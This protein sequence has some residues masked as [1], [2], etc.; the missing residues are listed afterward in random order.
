M[1]EFAT[2]NWGAL[3]SVLG[4][5]GSLAGLGWVIR[6]ARGA[7]A[8]SQAA[9]TAANETRDQISRHL[10]TVDLERA[11]GLIQHIKLLHDVSRWESAKE[12]YQ[13][14][15]AM[16]SNIIARCPEGST[17]LRQRLV[18]ARQQVRSMED[19]IGTG[20]NQN[21]ADIKRTDLNRQLN[22]I[23]YDLEE[24]ASGLGFDYPPFDYQQKE[25]K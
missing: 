20:I 18:V 13:P 14:L 21:V 23:Q 12:Q 5:V 19:F 22:Q 6:E 15:R 3:V 11:I 2:G 25:A 1:I 24:L 17:Q 16:L 10:Q 9:Q 7:R 8:A 4:L